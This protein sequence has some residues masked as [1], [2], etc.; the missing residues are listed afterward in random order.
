MLR[1][2]V[3]SALE[4]L[5]PRSARILVATSGGPDSQALLHALAT[6]HELVAAGIDHG[7][8]PAAAAELDYAE[9]LAQKL[10]IRFVRRA[11]RIAP[12]NVMQQARKARYTML[13]AIAQEYELAHIAMAHTASDQLEQLL[14]EIVRNN[15]SRGL[16]GIPE[17]RGMIVRPLLGTSRDEVMTYLARHGIKYAT[18]P[19]NNDMKRSR[20]RIRRDVVPVL[21]TLN[22]S[23]EQNIVPW[24]SDRRHDERI[25]DRRARGYVLAKRNR[26]KLPIFIP[27]VEHLEITPLT[28]TKRV[29]AT[30]LRM[31]GCIPRQHLVNRIMRGILSGGSRVLALEGSFDFDGKTLWFLPTAPAVYSLA[32]LVPGDVELA[33]SRINARLGD[34]PANLRSTL[35]VAFDADHLHLPMVVRGWRN[36]DKF[37]PF[38]GVG[39]DK[40]VAHTVKVSDLFINTKVPRALRNT[41]PVVVHGD[42]IVWV[43][44]LRRGNQAPITAQTRRAVTLAVLD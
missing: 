35:M 37:L 18:D 9:A 6:T 12:G 17:K 30:W 23:I 40:A 16:K 5:A 24:I 20:A 1:R 36:G 31:L 26:Q 27:P 2:R 25:L 19:S 14:L 11:V 22:P 33:Q 42:E 3:A 13:E 44:G 29:L 10:G 28:A 21:K 41:W 39:K 43:V 7:L 15:G 34:P 8:R 38:N 32:L 4:R